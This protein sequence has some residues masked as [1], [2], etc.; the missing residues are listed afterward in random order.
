MQAVMRGFSTN[1]YTKPLPPAPLSRSHATKNTIPGKGLDDDDLLNTS[2]FKAA[3][4]EEK[5]S[6]E[7]ELEATPKAKKIKSTAEESADELSATYKK[8]ARKLASSE[9]QTPVVRQK[10][11]KL[12]VQ[13]NLSGR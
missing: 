4:M 13:K 2:I 11:Q 10:K 6:E 12:P 8:S 9:S 1:L 5:E 7:S 3:E